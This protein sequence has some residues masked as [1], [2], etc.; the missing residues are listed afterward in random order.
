[1]HESVREVLMQ[2]ISFLSYQQQYACINYIMQTKTTTEL[3]H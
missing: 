2:Y 1:M 3:L